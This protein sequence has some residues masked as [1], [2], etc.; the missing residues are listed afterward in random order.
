MLNNFLFGIFN[1]VEFFECDNNRP[2]AKLN[3]INMF[4]LY[5]GAGNEMH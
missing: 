1:R 3:H 4:S 5:V 2:I